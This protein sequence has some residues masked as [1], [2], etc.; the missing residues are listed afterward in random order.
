MSRH[1][2]SPYPC[3]AP[4]C[5]KY[6][7]NGYFSPEALQKH[8][9]EIHQEHD[10]LGL[11]AKLHQTPPTESPRDHERFDKIVDNE[12]SSICKPGAGLAQPF[13]KPMIGRN[14]QDF[15]TAAPSTSL[16]TDH[17]D[18]SRDL[19]LSGNTVDDE[20]PKQAND[21]DVDEDTRSRDAYSFPSSKKERLVSGPRQLSRHGYV[22]DSGTFVD[23]A[24]IKLLR[25]Y[26]QAKCSGTIIDDFNQ[27][28]GVR[29]RGSGPSNAE[30]S[31][32]GGPYQAS[33]GSNSSNKTPQGPSPRQKRSRD[34]DDQNSQPPGKRVPLG[35][36]SS[37]DKRRWFACPYWKHDPRHH[38]ACS[39]LELTKISY[40]K[41]HLSRAHYRETYCERCLHISSNKESHQ[42]HLQ[43]QCEYRA[44]ELL[45]GI[46]HDQHRALSR[47]SNRAHTE[48]QKW[49]GIW[50]I[51][52][53][54]KTQPASPYI[55]LGVSQDIH[56]FREYLHEHGPS[57]L[58]RE[59]QA[60]GMTLESQQTDENTVFRAATNRALDMLFDHWAAGRSEEEAPCN[61]MMSVWNGAEASASRQP[62]PGESLPDSGID[63]GNPASANAASLP[64]AAKAPDA[65][66]VDDPSGQAGPEAQ[67]QSDPFEL[68]LDSF[69]WESFVQ[70]LGS[71]SETEGNVSWFHFNAHKGS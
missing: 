68:D 60:A 5:D 40:V 31:V 2:W 37:Q 41:Q 34:E 38:R 24:A 9:M 16:D 4:G 55:E 6:G 28:H 66:M 63:V 67:V 71:D 22:V 13:A 33:H 54:G 19:F 52:L 20:C 61:T 17:L 50:D 59:I 36:Q 51:V 49:Y 32:N 46:S 18:D 62:P 10:Q 14:Y 45:V 47:K 12:L 15:S 64:V 39:K 35:P 43:Q 69:D 7:E 44:P 27:A 48:S 26:H 29:T 3:L 11:D 70:E 1:D 58:R 65:D 57:T 21:A 53:P 56:E 42:A 23:N 25:A 30:A 8:R